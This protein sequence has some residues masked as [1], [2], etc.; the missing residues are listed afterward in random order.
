MDFET[1]R[2]LAHEMF[3]GIPRRFRAGVRALRVEREA[4]PH[5]EIQGI[6]TLGECW[7]E[8]WPSAYGGEGDVQSDLHLYHGS[9]RALARRDPGFDWEAELWETILHELLHHREAAAGTDELGVLDWAED[10]NQRRYQGLDW[11]PSFV[12]EIPEDEEGVRRLESEIFVEGEVVE[13]DEGESDVIFSW[14]GRRYTLRASARPGW[15]YVR[16]PNLAGGRLWVVVRVAESL[17]R[18]LLGLARGRAAHDEVPARPWDGGT[19]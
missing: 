8:E 18:R 13:P 5:P 19:P 17:W 11:D 15:T 2:H 1:F 7:S 4:E 3:D 14:R 12:L 9:F 16:V 10:Q 6:F